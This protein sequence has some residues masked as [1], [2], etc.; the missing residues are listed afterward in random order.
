M[1]ELSN[2][3]P[4][5]GATKDKKRKGRGIG[6]GLGQTAGRG[7]KGYTSRSGS[8]IN[9]S[10]EGG[11]M[12]L[13]RRLPK[14]GFSNYP[15]RTE[16]TVVNVS[17]LDRFENGTVVTP[18]ALRASGLVKGRGLVKVLGNGDLAKNLVVQAHAFS[19]AAAEK[20]AAGGG[21]AEVIKATAKA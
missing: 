17:D 18:E 11:Q 3:K 9:P 8:S 13:A 4:P 6:S 7:E 19:K 16:Y 15:F 21:K 10:F 14:V 20:I 2:L 5:K 12:P 1:N